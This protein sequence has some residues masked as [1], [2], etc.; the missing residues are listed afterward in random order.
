MKS[1]MCAPPDCRQL[2]CKII[3]FLKLLD[4]L[5]FKNCVLLV[6]VIFFI[7]ITLVPLVQFVQN[8]D[9]QPGSLSLQIPI[10]PISLVLLII[11]G[12]PSPQKHHSLCRRGELQVEKPG[13]ERSVSGNDGNLKWNY[14]QILKA[15]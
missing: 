6:V 14:I 3:L 4:F 8:L 13:G 1:T 15:A 9:Y 2:Y 11:P 7:A 10:G 12:S 5:T